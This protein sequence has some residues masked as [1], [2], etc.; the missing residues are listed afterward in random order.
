LNWLHE[1][2]RKGILLG[3]NAL[4]IMMAM[5]FTSKSHIYARNSL[6]YCEL[7]I[8]RTGKKESP[9]AELFLAK[10]TRVMASALA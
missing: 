9:E 5:M 7:I 8:F 6:G 4:V 2:K 10:G 3:K 1:T